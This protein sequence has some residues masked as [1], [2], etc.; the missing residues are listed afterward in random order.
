M[1]TFGFTDESFLGLHLQS[2]TGLCLHPVS[3][4]GMMCMPMILG[5]DNLLDVEFNFG[6]DISD[7]ITA[8]NP[9]R[10]VTSSDHSFEECFEDAG[11]V[12][13][14]AANGHPVHVDREDWP[15]GA[16]VIH[17]GDV[18]HGVASINFNLCSF[19]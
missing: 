12:Q 7:V 11:H 9:F 10:K 4:F 14:L 3:G 13:R 2:P 15:V 6:A 17:V 19:H 8:I 5:T 16:V 18:K 1:G